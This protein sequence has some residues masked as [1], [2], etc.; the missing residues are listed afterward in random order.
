[1]KTIKCAGCFRDIPIENKESL[2]EK[3]QK[4][5]CGFDLSWKENKS[6]EKKPVSNDLKKS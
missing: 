1:M 4:S 5:I 2:C 3:C 6:L